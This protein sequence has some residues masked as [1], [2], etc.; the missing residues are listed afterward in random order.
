MGV[1]ES[2]IPSNT[3]TSFVKEKTSTVKMNESRAEPD[4]DATDKNKLEEG[5]IFDD[6]E[7]IISSDE[8]LSMRKRIEELESRNAELEKI[9]NNL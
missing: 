7:D 9:A 4:A 6:Y 3:G 8:E 1:P 5:E 2:L